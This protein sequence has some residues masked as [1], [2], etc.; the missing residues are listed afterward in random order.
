MYFAGGF[1]TRYRLSDDTV[2]AL[3]TWDDSLTSYVAMVTSCAISIWAVGRHC[4]QVAGHQR[5]PGADGR[6]IAAAWHPSGANIIVVTDSGVLLSYAF[7]AGPPALLSL[8][9]TN[10]VAPAG[11][12]C[13]AAAGASL[14]IGTT[15]GHIVSVSW[16][17]ECEAYR[18]LETVLTGCPLDSSLP[19]ATAMCYCEQS[20]QLLLALDSGSVAVAK[21]NDD[22]AVFT[23]R[24]SSGFLLRAPSSESASCIAV[25]R[26]HGHLAVG[27]TNGEVL[28]Y[29]TVQP[30]ATVASRLALLEAQ[31]NGAV[32]EIGSVTQLTWSPEA[33]LTSGGWAPASCS[34]AVGYSAR[35]LA[36]WSLEGSYTFS[37]VSAT[38]TA[39]SDELS[40]HGS[41]AVGWPRD[42]LAVWVAERGRVGQ[43]TK[44][45][46]CAVQRGTETTCINPRSTQLVALTDELVLALS[47]P[48][49][50]G[51][52]MKTGEWNFRAPR[53]PS[54]CDYLAEN[55]PLTCSAADCCS[56][57]IAIAG[58]HGAAVWHG[59]RWRVFGNV[60]Q[61]KSI[62]CSAISW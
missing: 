20:K 35:G 24:A 16:W 6:T 2:V 51:S 43:M 4:K 47:P 59:G 22:D 49:E 19:V 48:T 55:R 54:G 42:G 61:E 41:V 21:F 36:L 10:P 58:K 11:V 18:L 52:G 27:L 40:A 12:S 30:G 57:S 3:L 38:E 33:M 56:G 44:L 60:L 13:M 37:S 39:D 32:N 29:R 14:V 62:S 46:L 9:A 34:L 28:I 15:D 7:T 5:Q 31:C 53:T 26:L 23:L 50:A 8:E 25:S 17:G 1:V 45:P